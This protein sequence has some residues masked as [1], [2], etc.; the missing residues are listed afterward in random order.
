MGK[1]LVHL[2]F[3]CVVLAFAVGVT[4]FFG[5]D[6]PDDPLG[7]KWAVYLGI[8]LAGAQGLHMVRNLPRRR[9]TG[10]DLPH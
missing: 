8:I 6:M 10:A 4:H 7:V 1:L 2:I 3:G 5:V 9:E